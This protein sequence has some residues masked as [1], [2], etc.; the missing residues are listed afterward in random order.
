MTNKKEIKKYCSGLDC[1][2][3]DEVEP[4]IY[5]IANKLQEQLER[6]EQENKKLKEDEK[7]L[8]NIIDNLQKEKNKWVEKYNDL[9]QD[10]DQLKKTCR[11]LRKC[12]KNNSALLDFEETNTTKLVNKV[13]KLEQTLTEIKEIVKNMNNECFYNDICDCNNCDMNGGCSH[14][15]KSI[16][17]DIINKAKER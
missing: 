12:Y 7:S 4:C 9:G 15:R 11:E 3:C 14:Y 2:T 1:L 10:F 8:L 17:L 13:M 6:K 5:R 16:I